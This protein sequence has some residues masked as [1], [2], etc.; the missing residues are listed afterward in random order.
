MF[1]GRKASREGE[2]KSSVPNRLAHGFVTALSVSGTNLDPKVISN[3]ANTC[4]LRLSGCRLLRYSEQTWISKH[5]IPLKVVVPFAS[6]LNIY[7]TFITN[8]SDGI[9]N[10]HTGNVFGSVWL[11]RVAHDITNAVTVHK[12]LILLL[13]YWQAISKD[14]VCRCACGDALFVKSRKRLSF[15]LLAPCIGK[16]FIYS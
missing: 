16:L 9:T 12:C 5:P 15:I 13:V 3:N 14:A 7:G 11:H 8:S 1:S 2:G 6:S 4:T 10:I